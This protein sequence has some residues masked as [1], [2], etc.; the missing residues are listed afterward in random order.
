MR[1]FKVVCCTCGNENVGIWNY[2]SE[3]EEGIKFKCSK[4][5]ASEK[6]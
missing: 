5:G 3:D 2:H 1:K 6:Q 4:C